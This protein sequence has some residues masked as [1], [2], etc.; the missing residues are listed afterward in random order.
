MDEN[1]TFNRLSS[2]L[3]LE[4]R[5]NLL[6]K[7]TSQSEIS[8]EPL[9]GES[10][11]FFAAPV[12]IEKQYEKAPWYY[13]IFYW[14]LGFFKSKSPL[15][16]YEDRLVAKLGREIEGQTPGLYDYERGILLPEF[17]KKLTELKQGSRF[18][19][20]ALDV[21]VNRDKGAFYAF[22][23]SLEMG[24]IHRRLNTETDP[25]FIA[26]GNPKAFE[27]EL[28]QIALRAMEDAM[29]VINEE[30][31]G[32]MYQHARSL[33]CLKELSSFLFDRVLTSF[34][35]ETAHSGPICS[36]GLVKDQL[37]ILN[38]ILFSLKHIPSM[39]LLESLFIF[40]LQEHEQEAG[41]NMETEIRKLLSQAE[42]SLVVIRDFNKEVPLTRIL[43]CV[44]RDMALSP[45]VISGGEDWFKVYQEYWK[46]HTEAR[47]SEYMR[48]RRHRD[49][50]NA[51]RSFLKGTNLKILNYVRSDYNPDG[52]PVSCSFSLSFLLTFYSAVF[53]SD[54]NKVLRQILI[55]GEFYKRENRTDFT[56]SY[57]ELIKLEDVIKKFE[58]EL[59]PSGEYGKRYSM[60]KGDM[61][62]LPIKRRKIQIVVE[63]ASDE[64]K[65][66]VSR[67]REALHTMLDILNGILRKDPTSKYDT[68]A[69]MANMSG[70]TTIF[71]DGIADTIQKVQ[72][73]L[74]LLD[75]ID[76][77]EIGR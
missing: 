30:Q 32:L 66:I 40:I 44:E 72:K 67:V 54:I 60:A 25:A 45:K 9:Y 50:L 22:L 24:E 10:A 53:I 27:S 49:L 64:A 75:D 19:Y 71:V 69:N 29:S 46:R 43:R 11:G 58:A 37:L 26:E 56:E 47:F 16:I 17:Y 2:E 36:A 34:I 68:L 51:F 76:I 6:K 41:F 74:Q 28:R 13:H 38:N 14:I 15:K 42:E 12:E 63:E 57:N 59:S 31:R 21:S 1:R 52:I 48:V 73:T 18:F 65:R 3:S 8:Q 70:K 20:T 35:F 62:S 39:P 4:E 77:M 23:A 61:S 5:N 33:Y 7:L 55:D